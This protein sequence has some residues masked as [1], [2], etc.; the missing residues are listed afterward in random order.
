M[1]TSPRATPIRLVKPSGKAKPKHANTNAAPNKDIQPNTVCRGLAAS[2]AAENPAS[3]TRPSGE[4]NVCRIPDQKGATS[5]NAPWAD[6]G[7][8]NTKIADRTRRDFLSK[9]DPAADN[10]DGRP[11]H[12]QGKGAMLKPRK[13]P[14]RNTGQVQ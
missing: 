12:S 7:G 9:E 14:D 6:A 5:V 1:A 2:K 4:A 10:R 3:R 13:Q 8:I 11:A